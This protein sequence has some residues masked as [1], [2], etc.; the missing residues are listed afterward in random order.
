MR[1]RTSFCLRQRAVQQRRGQVSI[2]ILFFTGIFLLAIS[3]IAVFAA[4]ETTTRVM[5]HQAQDAVT[6]LV[7]A[8]D[9]AYALGPGSVEYVTVTIP[10]GLY[11]TE[12]SRKSV[13]IRIHLNGADFDFHAR[14][15][16]NLTGELPDR[17]GTFR[18]KA[19]ALDT[20]EVEFEQA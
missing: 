4:R 14:S 11:D 3:I 19:T 6:T 20:G 15:I 5:H 8:A 10:G 13:L 2:E 12:V 18:V 1:S 17:K 16:A 9:T 7:R